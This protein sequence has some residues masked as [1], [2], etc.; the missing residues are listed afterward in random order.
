MDVTYLQIAILLASIAGLLKK[1]F[2]WY[3]WM[4]AGAVE[5]IFFAYGLLVFV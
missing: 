3:G 1:K 2:I 5:I 4:I